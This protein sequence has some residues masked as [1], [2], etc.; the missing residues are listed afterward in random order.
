MLFGGL[1]SIS[2]ASK[3]TSSKAIVQP[4][5]IRAFTLAGFPWLMAK[6]YDD[7][8]MDDESSAEFSLDGELPP[9]HVHGLVTSVE[10]HESMERLSKEL[11]N[12]HMGLNEEEARI[13]SLAA[14]SHHDRL[15]LMRSEAR[16][17]AREL[18]LN[19][20]SP[21]VAVTEAME[22]RLIDVESYM[23]LSID[24]LSWEGR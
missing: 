22:K 5:V 10:M 4:E 20:S 15:F 14:G 11:S 6:I 1:A 21:L 23:N 24:L 2:A 8:V 13:I 17:L 19:P 9:Y 12:A 3:A 7:I 18:G 16:E